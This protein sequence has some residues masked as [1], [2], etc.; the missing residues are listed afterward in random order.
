MISN[1]FGSLQ[2]SPK[3]ANYITFFK[4]C[5]FHLNIFPFHSLSLIPSCCTNPFRKKTTSERPFTWE[6]E[7]FC[8]TSLLSYFFGWQNYMALKSWIAAPFHE[9]LPP[10]RSFERLLFVFKLLCFQF[11]YSPRASPSLT[12]TPFLATWLTVFVS[13]CLNFAHLFCSY[14]RWHLEGAPPPAAHGAKVVPAHL[15]DDG[16]QSTEIF[17]KAKRLDEGFLL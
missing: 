15:A 16:T 3:A 7:S 13:L 11:L 9:H 8:S 6:Y 10:P 1:M 5:H 14:G 12:T 17:V 4:L 2:A